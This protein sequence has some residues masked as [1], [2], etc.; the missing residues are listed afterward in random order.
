MSPKHTPKPSTTPAQGP[1]AIEP[2]KPVVQTAAS[3]SMNVGG[4][5]GADEPI[6]LA[7]DLLGAGASDE[8]SPAG[9][10]DYSKGVTKALGWDDAWGK[11]KGP[12]EQKMLR[13]QELLHAEGVV[14]DSV[15][16]NDGDEGAGF[17]LGIGIPTPESKDS[18]PIV[19]T[20]T[21]WDAQYDEGKPGDYWIS[22]ET[23]G[24]DALALG[25]YAPGNYTNNRYVQSVESLLERI[26]GLD[27]A[28]SVQ[29][30]IEDGRKNGWQL[31]RKK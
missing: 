30:I 12:L 1:K 26:E 22:F 18:T 31:H 11:V 17:V 8:R 3:V 14:T 25:L 5:V 13:I 6:G 19:L 7:E 23:V 15:G 20:G 10:R 4:P 2:E 21:L 27:V 16:L 9:L 29:N 28:A 24:V